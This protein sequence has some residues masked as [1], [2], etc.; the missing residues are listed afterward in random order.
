MYQ[1][2][3]SFNIPLGQPPGHLNFW[4]I[5]VEIPPPRAKKL[6]KCLIIGLFQVIKWPHRI[7]HPLGAVIKCFAPGKTKARVKRRTLHEPNSIEL[8][9]MN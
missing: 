3:G 9:Y 4:K 7:P 1:S 2:N 5:F 6:F 8:I